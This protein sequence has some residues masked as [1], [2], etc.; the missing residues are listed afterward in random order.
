MLLCVA[1]DA[2]APLAREL[3]RDVLHRQ[4]VL[5]T[6]GYLPV[7][8]LA[9]LRRR[10]CAIGRL[11]PLAPIP[12]GLEHTTL[13]QSFAIEGDARAVLAATK[14]IRGI[15]ARAL[16]LKKRRGAAQAYHAGASLLSGGLV[17]LFHLAEQ[18]MSSSV[19]S[20]AVLNDALYDFAETTL[21]NTCWLGP[22][23]A[24]TGALSRG[25][26][27]LVRGHLAALGSSPE[28]HQLYC[29]LGRTMLDLAQARG[30]I[31]EKE[32]H[33]LRALLHIKWKKRELRFRKRVHR[34]DRWSRG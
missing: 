8:C 3:A 6:N 7:T 13:M 27:P 10:G 17:A 18:V 12:S 26:E 30:S 2:F 24:L 23:Q 34:L 16:F 11:H 19:S 15:E 5:F 9:P 1:D 31:D 33:R 20:R 22:K 21:W 4:V 25:S 29:L 14:I 28:I 32:A